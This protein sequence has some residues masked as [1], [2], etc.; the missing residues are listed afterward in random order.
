MLR[1]RSGSH[2]TNGLPCWRMRWVTWPIFQNR[3]HSIAGTRRPLRI[4]TRIRL[5][6]VEFAR[7]PWLGPGFIYFRPFLLK[8]VH[9]PF[10]NIAASITDSGERSRICCRQH[11]NMTNL[12]KYARPIQ[13]IRTEYNFLQIADC[14]FAWSTRSGYWGSRFYS[15]GI[16][17][18]FKDIVFSFGLLDNQPG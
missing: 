15:L 11:I 3:L 14:C 9:H 1:D 4:H 16:L 17:S 13:T 6:S 8:I 5:P 12:L 10:R 7:P 2:T 18:F